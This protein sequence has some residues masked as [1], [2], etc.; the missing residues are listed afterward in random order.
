M[1]KGRIILLVVILVGSQP[2]LACSIF[3]QQYRLIGY[4]DGGPF[5]HGIRQAQGIRVFQTDTTMTAETRHRCRC[6]GAMKAQ[7]QLGF[8]KADEDR[9]QRIIR[10]GR[11]HG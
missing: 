11:Y 5:L 10:S 9:P 2:Q 3:V 6:V 7:A 4:G 8:A 1:R